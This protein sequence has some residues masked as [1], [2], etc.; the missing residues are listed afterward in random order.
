MAGFFYNLF[1]PFQQLKDYEAE[2]QRMLESGEA[3]LS[4]SPDAYYE[5]AVGKLL[6]EK[7]DPYNVFE[8]IQ[9]DNRLAQEQAATVAYQREMDSTNAANTFAAEQAQL[10]RDWQTQANQKAM[11]FEAQQAE[12]NRKWQEEQT[13]TAYQRAVKDLKAAGLNPILAVGGSGA[14]SGAGA[15]ASGVSSAGATAAASK[16]NAQKADVDVTTYRE[17]LNAIVNG[18]FQLGSTTINGLFNLG[19]SVLA[20]KSARSNLILQSSMKKYY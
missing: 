8:R 5:N 14:A 3:E 7:N 13:S 16:A 6:A 18:A 1:H 15:Q 12:I 20:G 17:L 2:K 9:A 19:S 10:N 4:F 11:D